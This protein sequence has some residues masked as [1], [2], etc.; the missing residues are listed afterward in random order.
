MSKTKRKPSK[1]SSEAHEN[2]FKEEKEKKKFSVWEVSIYHIR[3]NF[4]VTILGFYKVVA[5]VG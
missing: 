4:G 5:N 3:N 1:V 2:L